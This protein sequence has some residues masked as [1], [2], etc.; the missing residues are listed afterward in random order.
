MGLHAWCGQHVKVHWSINHKSYSV[1]HNNRVVG[2]TSAINLVNVTFKVSETSRQRVLR[3]RRKNVHAFVEG[4]VTLESLPEVE[5][6]VEYDPYVFRG[7]VVTGDL[8]SIPLSAADSI[9]MIT[10]C[11]HPVLVAHNTR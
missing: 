10:V 5:T 2:Y 1:A 9:S 4:T 3:E 11:G 6:F 7:F 8:W